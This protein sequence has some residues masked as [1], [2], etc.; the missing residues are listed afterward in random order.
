MSSAVEIRDAV[1]DAFTADATLMALLT[2]GESG[3]KVFDGVADREQTGRWIVLGGSTE[4]A[5]STFGR[6]GN[7]GGL[8]I[9]I[10]D[11]PDADEAPGLGRVEAIWKEAVRVLR[12]PLSLA[13]S[14]FR[15]ART[16]YVDAFIEQDGRTAT[17]VGRY[18]PRTAE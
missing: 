17:L 4:T 16:T 11:V 6:E 9:S 15:G 7:R 14:E 2:A 1:H 13:E 18:E 12:Q 3:R 10:H 8:R 5:L